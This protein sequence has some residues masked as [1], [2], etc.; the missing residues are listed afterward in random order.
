M[1]AQQFA[2]GFFERSVAF[3]INVIAQRRFH[4][5][6]EFIQQRD[7]FGFLL[8]LRRQ[9]EF[10]LSVFCQNRRRRIRISQIKRRGEFIGFRFRQAVNI[11]LAAQYEKLAYALTQYG[12]DGIGEHRLHLARRPGQQYDRAIALLHQLPRSRAVVIHQQF[13]AGHQHGLANVI[14]GHF[15]PAP[16]EARANGFKRRFVNCQL[17]A[18]YARENF[19]RHIVFSR[20]ESAG[21]N[22]DLRPL[23]RIPN[24]LFE[25]RFIIADDGF[26][27]DF[28]AQRVELF[29]EPQRIGVDPKRRQH[30]RTDSENFCVK[31]GMNLIG[32]ASVTD[33]RI[34]TEE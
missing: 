24:R 10:D 9:V 23:H 28:D 5:R 1:R 19:F 17:A 6:G 32:D 26:E 21:R 15:H 2:H 4:L 13:R 3:G 30:F 12:R 31:H 33:K 16:S 11:E 27:F 20:A 18:Q 29:G 34:S 8:G 22:D 14:G 7:G 25:S